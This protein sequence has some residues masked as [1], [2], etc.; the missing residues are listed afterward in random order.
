MKKE[1]IE[2]MVHPNIFVPL[3]SNIIVISI[4][5]S[6]SNVF[7]ARNGNFYRVGVEN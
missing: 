6:T 5:E 2:E 1:D 7:L 4:L 3:L